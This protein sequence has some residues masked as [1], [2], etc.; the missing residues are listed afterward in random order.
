MISLLD[1]NYNKNY[2]EYSKIIYDTICYN[3]FINNKII[4]NKDVELTNS[5]NKLLFVV[6]DKEALLKNIS[7][8]GYTISQGSKQ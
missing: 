2:F 8:K 4:I 1:T 7:D 5:F 6:Q 3:K